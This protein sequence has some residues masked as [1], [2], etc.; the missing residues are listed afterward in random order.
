MKLTGVKW[1][2]PRLICI[3][4]DLHTTLVCG[5]KRPFNVN[6]GLQKGKRK[7]TPLGN[8]RAR[9]GHDPEIALSFSQGQLGSSHLC[10]VKRLPASM[11]S[12]SSGVLPNTCDNLSP[13]GC[14]WW[15]QETHSYYHEDTSLA[16]A[17]EAPASVTKML[18]LASVHPIIVLPAWWQD[19]LAC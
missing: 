4:R 15:L 6:C 5:G 13:R 8:Y 14:L 10:T 2:C 19:I 18:L 11:C 3:N 12:K 17:L 9:Y 16:S 1:C 7:S